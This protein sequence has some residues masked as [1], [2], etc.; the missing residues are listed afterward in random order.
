MANLGDLAGLLFKTVSDNSGNIASTITNTVSKVKKAA[1]V[2]AIK[3]KY[4]PGQ[5]MSAADNAAL[6]G[7]QIK[8]P[9]SLPSTSLEAPKGPSYK[10][11]DLPVEGK[12]AVGQAQ[13]DIGTRAQI[14]T[15]VTGELLTKGASEVNKRVTNLINTTEEGSLKR[16]FLQTGQAITA[17]PLSQ[18]GEG[19]TQISGGE[20]INE[21]PQIVKGLTNVIFGGLGTT[22]GGAAFNAIINQPEVKP[23]ADKA[24]GVLGAAKD[25]IRNLPIIKDLPEEAKSAIDLGVDLAAFEVLHKAIKAPFK[26]TEIMEVPH[27][28]TG[29]MV[30]IAVPVDTAGWRAFKQD[31]VKQVNA[32]KTDPIKFLKEQQVGLSIKDVSG[33]LKPEVH[34]SEATANVIDEMRNAF[35][36]ERFGVDGET[37]SYSSTF[38]EW[39]PKELRDSSLFRKVEDNILENSVPTSKRQLE[40]YNIV[41]EKI[42]SDYVPT[43]SWGEAD[44]ADYSTKIEKASK[45]E[46]LPYLDQGLKLGENVR[47]TKAYK[48][49][50]K[51]ITTP[52]VTLPSFDS[53]SYV[54]DLTEKA[55]PKDLKSDLKTTAKNFIADFKSKIIDS[56]API[57]DA[58]VSASKEHGFEVLPKYDITNQI[59]RTLRSPTLAGQFAEDYGLI[60]VIRDV[61]DINKLDQYLIANQALK[62]ESRGITTGRDLLKDRMLVNELSPEYSQYAKRVTD[63][64][65]KVLDYITESGLISKELSTKL[66]EVYP[67]YVPMKRLFT[68]LEKGPASKGNKNLASLSSQSVIERLEGSKREIESPS[69]SLL[70]KT[71]DAFRQG[72]VNKTAELLAGMR[73]LPGFEDK[74]IEL[75]KGEEAPYTFSYLENGEKK[76]FKTT[77][78]ISEAAKQLNAEEAGLLV[79]VLRTPT[80]LFKM[81]TT[82][83]EPSF[84]AVNIVKDQMTAFINSKHGLKTSIANPGN[85][86]K[87]LMSVLKHDDLYKE[88]VREGAG[89]TSFDVNRGQVKNTI[90]RVRAGRSKASAILYTVTHPGEMLRVVEDIVGRSEELGRLTQYKGTKEAL[91]A[92]GRTKEDATILASKAARE[93]T[94]NFS[95]KGDW[96]NVINTI[97][98]FNASMQGSRALIRAFIRDPKS[99]TFKVAAT[100]FLP[101][102]AVTAW[103]ISDPERKKAY[104]DI[105]DYEKEG[106]FIIV[107][108]NPTF[109]EKTGKWNVIKV[110]MAPGASSLSVPVRKSI[111][112]AYNTDPTGAGLDFV[113]SILETISPLN[114]KSPSK[115]LGNILPQGIKAPVENVA[116][117]DFFKESPIIPEGLQG[118]SPNLQ[119]KGNTSEPAKIIGNILGVSPIQIDHLISG[120]S[121]K[122][123]TEISGQTSVGEAISGR[124]TQ[125]TGGK[126]VSEAYSKK[127]AADLENKDYNFVLKKS[128]DKLMETKDKEGMKTL[129]ESLDPEKQ[130]YVMSYLKDKITK[131]KGGVSAVVN[132]FNSDEAI[133]Y[134]SDKIDTAIKNS[135]NAAMRK[136]VESLRSE[137]AQKELLKHII[138]RKAELN[139]S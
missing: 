135:D 18:V 6:Q 99:T 44:L 129:L 103:N 45:K 23:V 38:P 138:L 78:E 47:P 35:N 51:T 76:T 116:N 24:F 117:Y 126:E 85:F 72:E 20:N 137:A 111:E 69:E 42:E 92:E 107:P 119:V 59:D 100:V 16:R 114:L 97:P 118:L 9:T 94:A 54:K 90:A 127:N 2:Q 1:T 7:T 28:K 77:K 131:N 82:G 37:V 106:N 17:T 128:V 115:F 96:G 56:A 60:S 139:K 32:I 121:G 74:I 53:E 122:L 64:S 8:P 11:S 36:G 22:G 14:L 95:R 120:Y 133:K 101:I 40:L 105:L 21:Q 31:L 33:G 68:E 41:K 93:N 130:S 4:Q 3:S 86:V 91:I 66:K 55:N 102:A 34:R 110:P 112:G 124:F 52:D 98:Y 58:L 81:G 71:Y 43:Q 46:Q 65:N 63:Y 62:A 113:N 12:L 25:G 13:P 87:S 30:K 109:D 132:D 79:K 61:P 73:N 15:N 123:G 29:E 57:E 48:D 39:I 83:L 108:P 10:F 75:K 49:L 70:S 5:T 89:G 104:D 136:M 80:R 19:L 84:I 125:A 67:D 50:Q 26:T 134:Y 27:P 88:M